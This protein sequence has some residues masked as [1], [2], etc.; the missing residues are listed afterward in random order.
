MILERRVN[1][2]AASGELDNDYEEFDR[3]RASIED[4]VG[5]EQPMGG[6]QVQAQMT[7]RIRMRWRDDV[8][9]TCRIRHV[10]DH[11]APVVEDVYDIAGPP[12]VDMRTGRREMILLCTKRAADG[13]RRGGTGD[14]VG[15]AILTESGEPLLTESGS[16]I[17]G[18]ET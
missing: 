17:I 12:Q 3:D 4:L 14:E 2:Q 9:E 13:W 1:D 7:T 15:N 6:A 18:E 5:R 16:I 11:D 10:V 8:D